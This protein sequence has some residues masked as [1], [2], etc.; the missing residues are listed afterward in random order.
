MKIFII[1]AVRQILGNEIKKDKMN[2]TRST[3]AK[4]EN[5]I[6]HFSRK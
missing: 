1:C 4:V 2:G 3:G 6:Q 5:C